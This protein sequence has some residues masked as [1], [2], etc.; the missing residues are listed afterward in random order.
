MDAPDCPCIPTRE[1]GEQSSPLEPTCGAE[2]CPK[3]TGGDS[4]G[5]G[6]F[7]I[8]NPEALECALEALRDRTPGIIRWDAQYE[9]G[10]SESIGYV[11]IDADGQGFSRDWGW[12]DLTF[13]AEDALRGPLKDASAF[14]ACLGNA[15]PVVQLDCVRNALES[16]TEICDP[17]WYE[18]SI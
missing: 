6:D 7:E 1:E 16:T 17:E 18:E 4:F 2:L 3:I 11:L 14:D 5:T 13:I 10:Q 15:N 12:Q 8:T 9:G